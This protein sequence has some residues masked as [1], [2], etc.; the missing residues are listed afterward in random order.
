[1]S[2]F[3]EYFVQ[4]PSGE[5]KCVGV[6]PLDKLPADRKLGWAGKVE[7]TVTEDFTVMR[8]FRDVKIKASAKRSLR[9]RTIIQ[10]LNQV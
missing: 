10:P 7:R 5:W 6:K 8:C 2:H 3:E 9:V 4:Q 1:M